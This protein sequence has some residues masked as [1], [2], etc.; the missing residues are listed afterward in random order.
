MRNTMVVYLHEES[1]VL[2]LDSP[3]HATTNQKE[4]VL[5]YL[6][7]KIIVNMAKCMLP[8]K[9]LNIKVFC[10]AQHNA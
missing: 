3:L 1:L 9:M 8:R 4:N 2:L 5:Q 10:K 6:T 7:K